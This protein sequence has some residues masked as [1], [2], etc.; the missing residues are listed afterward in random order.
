M[1]P[2]ADGRA[3]KSVL[4]TFFVNFAILFSAAS[5]TEITHFTFNSIKREKKYDL[6]ALVRFLVRTSPSCS[7]VL[8]NVRKAERGAV[9]GLYE[10]MF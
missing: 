10:N 3:C 9:I 4:K 1:W 2:M 8:S 5:G 7:V 6:S